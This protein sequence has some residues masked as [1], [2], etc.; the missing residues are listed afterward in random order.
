M[1]ELPEVEVVRLGLSPHVVGRRILE[2]ICCHQKLRLPV[3]K[4]KL[5]RWVVG[6]K[7]AALERRAKYLLFQMDNGNLSMLGPEKQKVITESSMFER[8]RVV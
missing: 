1:P 7:V 3:P 4:K 2:V 8:G 6:A 5:G